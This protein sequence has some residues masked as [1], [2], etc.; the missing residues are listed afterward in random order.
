MGKHFA[1][2]TKK[3]QHFPLFGFS[4]KSLKTAIPAAFFI[5][6]RWF[7]S[8]ALVIPS[9]FEAIRGKACVYWGFHR[10]RVLYGETFG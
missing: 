8:T 4:P 7:S 9:G 5:I 2:N 10:L 3:Y 6:S 1:K